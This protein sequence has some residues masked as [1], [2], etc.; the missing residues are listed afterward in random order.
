MATN[1]PNFWISKSVLFIK[2]LLPF[3]FFFIGILWERTITTHSYLLILSLTLILLF[4]I[5]NS[6]TYYYHGVLRKEFIFMEDR[7]NAIKK[8]SKIRLKNWKKIADIM[9]EQDI[10]LEEKLALIL[11][12]GLL[13]A[14]ESIETVIKEVGEVFRREVV[15]GKIGIPPEMTLGIF[16]IQK[17][18]DED[19]L[20]IKHNG[21]YCNK[22]GDKIKQDCLTEKRNFYKNDNTTA[23]T[24]WELGEPIFIE[25]TK[26]ELE[27]PEK[28]RA[29]T[30]FYGTEDT[31]SICCLPVQQD[32]LFFGVLCIKSNMPH[33][34]QTNYTFQTKLTNSFEP[35]INQLA[36]VE[37]VKHV[38]N[39]YIK[40]RL[41]PNFVKSS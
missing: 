41:S 9:E 26:K 5:M 13:D 6:L 33:I 23:G 35:I 3:I 38:K 25:D 32:N 31:K 24:V 15:G 16:Y 1:K 14:R 21:F 40:E 22:L 37:L 11:E 36:L 19:C 28:E 34:I 30:N 7:V 8:V 10:I 29:F 18:I 20:A 2:A 39:S 17:K 4:A 12:Q 27:K